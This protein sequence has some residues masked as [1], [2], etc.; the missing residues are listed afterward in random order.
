MARRRLAPGFSDATRHNYAHPRGHD[1]RWDIGGPI[2][3]SHIYLTDQR[4]QACADVLAGGQR[5]E[6]IDRVAFDDVAA[7]RIIEMLGQQAMLGDAASGLA[8]EQ[9]IDLLCIQLVREHSGSWRTV[10]V[11]P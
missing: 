4:L 1:G 3:L 9:A 11:S 10:F 5:V 7:S 2:E 8:V 6:L